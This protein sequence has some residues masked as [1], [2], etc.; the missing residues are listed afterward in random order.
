[1]AVI[2]TRRCNAADTSRC[3]SIEPPMVTVG[4][5]PLDAVADSAHH[6]LYVTDSAF[7]NSRGA[8]SMIGTSHCTGADTSDCAAQTPLTTPMRRFPF[9]AVLD[10]ATKTLYVANFSNADLSP[11]NTATCNA[12]DKSGCPALPPEIVVGS[13]PI[14]LALDA[15]N[16]TIYV[17]NNG[18]GTVSP[19]ATGP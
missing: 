18:D 7:G 14:A 16:H 9:Q 8:L 1:V 10:P 17:S 3:A 11:I 12:R 13:Q 19:V 5:D 6:T 4:L 15:D 2:D